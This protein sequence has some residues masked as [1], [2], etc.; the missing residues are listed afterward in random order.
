MGSSQQSC[1]QST[2]GYSI[3]HV[4][5]VYS[6]NSYYC[7]LCEC[8]V[9]MA[10]ILKEHMEKEH[11]SHLMK[12][13]MAAAGAVLAWKYLPSMTEELWN[14]ALLFLHRHRAEE[15]NRHEITDLYQFQDPTGILEKHKQLLFQPFN[16][17]KVCIKCQLS[18]VF[19]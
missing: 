18:H 13:L 12:P 3:K 15:D 17:N 7:E 2:H 14:H 1:Y 9:K 5:S 16:E 4:N 6:V 11:S 10:S 19:Y 8:G